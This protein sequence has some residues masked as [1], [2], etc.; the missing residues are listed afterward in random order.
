MFNADNELLQKN[1]TFLFSFLLYI[2]EL[3]E[4]LEFI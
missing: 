3:K 2:F 1:R 4:V